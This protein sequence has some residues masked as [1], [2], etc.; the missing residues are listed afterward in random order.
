VRNRARDLLRRRRVRRHEPLEAPPGEPPL[1]EIVDRSSGPEDLASRAEL[2]RRLW[3]ALGELTDAQ[4]EILVLRDYQD[5]RY[6]EIAEVLEVPLG[7]VMSRLH[8]A[9]RALRERVA[10]WAGPAG[11]PP[12]GHHG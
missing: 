8:R 10:G 3:E 2:A 1:R 5:L 11:A 6:E 12:R 4:R 9:R 7:T